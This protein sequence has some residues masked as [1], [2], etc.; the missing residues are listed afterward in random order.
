MGKT[1]KLEDLVE[2][3]LP[4]TF[5]G[6]KTA[7]GRKSLITWAPDVKWPPGKYLQVASVA[8]V[9]LGGVKMIECMSVDPTHAR[10]Y[11]F[12]DVSNFVCERERHNDGDAKEHDPDPEAALDFVEDLLRTKTE[13]SK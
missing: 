12:E 6:W 3:R 10:Y 13:A 7:F 8:L 9:Q 5:V 1:L 4:L 11:S 2:W